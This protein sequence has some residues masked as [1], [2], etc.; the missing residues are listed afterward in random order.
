MSKWKEKHYSKLKHNECAS[1]KE[2][3]IVL[4][5]LFQ[6]MRVRFDERKTVDDFPLSD[7]RLELVVF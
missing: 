6:A 1:S 2:E 4:R 7:K 5:L 3:G